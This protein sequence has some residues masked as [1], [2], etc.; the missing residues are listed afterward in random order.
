MKRILSLFLAMVM[1]VTLFTG[2][3]KE[4]LGL[5]NLTKEVSEISVLEGDENIDIDAEQLFDLIDKQGEK[6]GMELTT[7][8][9]EVL[10]KIRVF[11][12]ENSIQLLVKYDKDNIEGTIE[13]N[14]VTKKTSEKKAFTTVILKGEKVYINIEQIVSYLSDSGLYKADELLNIKGKSMK[15]MMIDLNDL[16]NSKLGGL[17][18]NIGTDQKLTDK[19]IAFADEL[20]QVV[21][22]DLTTNQVEKIGTDSYSMSVNGEEMM[23]VAFDSIIYLINNYDDFADAFVDLLNTLTDEELKSLNIGDSREEIIGSFNESR[24]SLK[25]NKDTAISQMEMSKQMMKSEQIKPILESILMK[26]SLAK[27]NSTTYTDEFSFKMNLTPTINTILQQTGNTEM[28][29]DDCNISIVATSN[30]KKSSSLNIIVPTEGVVNAKDIKKYAKQKLRVNIDHGGYNQ[31]I[32]E[33]PTLG[34]ENLDIKVIN[35]FSYLPAR[36][37]VEILGDE[38]NWDDASKK[39]YVA[40]DGQNVYLEGVIVNDR[41]YIKV[42]ELEKIGY[43]VNWNETSR[44]VEIEK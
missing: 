37:V 12:K 2:C 39:A 5:W 21:F 14:V 43:K 4:E 24:Q 35:D 1:M 23:D 30:I 42:R 15:Y 44:E 22:K 18:Y 40:V 20:I 36:K 28:I 9:K 16:D 11:L 26:Y 27:Q 41:T 31:T 19:Y 32:S 7:E 25:E 33:V 8:E 6:L 13:I 29:K 17:K 10:N 38:I 3:T 34:Y